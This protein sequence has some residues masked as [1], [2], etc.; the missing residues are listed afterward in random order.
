MKNQWITFVSSGALVLGL[1]VA[2]ISFANSDNIPP[3]QGTIPV[4][5][6]SE[7]DFPAMAKISLNR[8]MENALKSNSGRVLKAE[9]E[10]EDGFL[11]YSIEV[12][13]PDHSTMEVVLDAGSGKILSMREDKADRDD[14]ENGGHERG[15]HEDHEGDD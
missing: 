15:E 9:L 3:I 12:V 13:A 10:D 14:H 11:V 1:T 2:A 5:D 8:A 7:A 4:T 6:Q